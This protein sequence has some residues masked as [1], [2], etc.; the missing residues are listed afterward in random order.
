MY[1]CRIHPVSQ[2]FPLS[3]FM[4]MRLMYHALLIH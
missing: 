4:V 2:R 3:F 1:L